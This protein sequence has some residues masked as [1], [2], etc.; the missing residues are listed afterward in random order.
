MNRTPTGE[1]TNQFSGSKSLHAPLANRTDDGAHL[2]TDMES[3]AR[4]RRGPAALRVAQ[5]L[6][7]LAVLGAIA[8]AWTFYAATAEGHVFPT[9]SET[10]RGFWETLTSG[11]DWRATLVSW[12]SL[13][14]GYAVAA[15]AGIA[16][17]LLLGVSRIADRLFGV[18]LDLMLVVPMIVI[19]PI[20][21]I[22]L[23]VTAKAEVVVIIFFAVPYVALPTRT[24]VREMPQLWF[25]VFA[26]LGANR[27]RLWRYLLV[28]GSRA[29]IVHGLR[30]GLAHALSG[31]F[32]VELTLVALGVGNVILQYRGQ[33]EFGKMIGYIGLLMLQV[34]VVMSLINRV[35][36]SSEVTS[37]SGPK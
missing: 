36:R 25:D 20:V 4:N 9:V 33:F 34:L 29:G 23:G 26:S 27:A 1:P 11:A 28:P 21:L 13:A 30:L 12:R 24:V 35:D 18:Y 16:L 32:V 17:G 7:P 31:L 2:T 19:M 37:L 14:I 10:V 3:P 15:V 6:L 5:V 22:A 8:I